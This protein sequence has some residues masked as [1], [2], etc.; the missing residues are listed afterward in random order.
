MEYIHV[1]QRLRP[2]RYAFLISDGDLAAALRA[3]SINTA[4]WGG[5]YNPIVAL[6]PKESRDGVLKAFD[7]D[8]I[9]NLTGSVLP[10]D[11]ASRYQDR[12]I[13]E[14][15]LVFTDHHTKKRELGVGFDILPVIRNVHEKMRNSTEPSRAVIVTPH[16]LAGWPEYNAFCYGSFQWL[17]AMD[18][19]F[20]EMYRLA[21]RARTEDLPELRPPPADDSFFPLEFTAHGL[22]VLR[23]GTGFS[24]HVV[25]IGDHRSL[26]DLIEF[27]N[28]RATGRTAIFV[29]AS[30]YQ[31]FEAWIRMVA[32]E[33]RYPINQQIENQADLQKGPSLGD[34]RFEEICKWI[35]TFGLGQLP[36]RN[37]VPRYGIEMEMYAGDIDVA[38]LLASTGEEISILDDGRMTPVKLIRPP[39]VAPTFE[40]SRWSAWSIEVSMSGSY[41]YPE[42]MFSLPNEPVIDPL[43]RR[44]MSGMLGEVRIGQRGVIVQQHQ[45]PHILH[46]SPISTNEVIHALLAQAGIEAEPS[47]PGRY[48]EQIIKKMGNLQG[49]C[50]VFK[51]RGV[52][53]ILDK[54]GEGSVLTKGN[55]HD[56]AMSTTDDKYGRNWRPELYEKLILRYGQQGALHFGNIFD[57]LLDQRI[58]RPGLT[59]KCRTCFKEDWY[60]V[61]EFTEEYTCRYCFTSQRVKF[62]SAREWQYKADG[63]FQIRDSGQGS[64]AVILSLWRLEHMAHS[65]GRWI[66]S[67]NILTRSDGARCEIDYVYVQT[68]MLDTKYDLVIG[69][70]TRFGDFTDDDMKKMSGLADRF[71]RKPFLAFTTL[72][73]QFSEQDKVRLRELSKRG[74]KVIALTREEIDPYDLHDRFDKAPHKYAVGLRELSRNT[75]YL[76]VDR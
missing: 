74:Y 16:A 56:I 63:L 2:A 69:Q 64:V 5:I 48:A 6:G 46:V 45:S 11:L 31:A 23:G 52:R 68:G 41:R 60:H 61:S 10:N 17:P 9:I 58:I 20:D 14:A 50:R 65:S 67:R 3:V 4:L 30:E 35:N 32:T 27:W 12:I 44:G 71:N 57:E 26:A 38:E 28:I 8:A 40:R 54:L 7:P 75:I 39:F 15:E 70:A 25:F 34:D 66:T 47:Q 1:R 22:R 49:D 36:R 42:L 24:S 37:W 53:Q 59:F 55:M 43:A 18:V 72:R 21:L 19:N 29:L 62:G 73:D 13:S 51:V 76:N 33:G